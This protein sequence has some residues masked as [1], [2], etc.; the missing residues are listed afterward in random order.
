MSPLGKVGMSQGETLLSSEDTKDPVPT[1]AGRREE[2][3]T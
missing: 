2:P 3:Q 1:R